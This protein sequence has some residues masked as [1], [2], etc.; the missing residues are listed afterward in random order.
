MFQITEQF[1][2]GKENPGMKSGQDNT[3]RPVGDGFMPSLRNPRSHTLSLRNL[4]PE[5]PVPTPLQ[6]TV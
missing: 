1:Q 2:T 3:C 4:Y 6:P 5:E